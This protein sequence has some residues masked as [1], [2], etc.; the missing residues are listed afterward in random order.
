[1]KSSL[2]RR[3]LSSPTTSS[4]IA[5]VER[6]T[7][8][9]PLLIL[10]SGALRSRVFDG[11]H[12]FR[13]CASDHLS[14][15]SKLQTLFCCLRRHLR[16][17]GSITTAV[18]SV[19]Q[20]EEGRGAGPDPEDR[21]PLEMGVG[22]AYD[23]L[24]E[25]AALAVA[26]GGSPKIPCRAHPGRLVPAVGPLSSSTAEPE[27]M[28]VQERAKTV[29]AVT[30]RRASRFGGLLAQALRRRWSAPNRPARRRSRTP[31]IDL[32]RQRPARGSGDRRERLPRARLRHR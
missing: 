1:M 13:W 6:N 27:E 16:G 12:G 32:H 7:T 19:A 15:R 3:R 22:M 30:I 9:L 20:A 28:V 23:P 31:P 18:A 11:A 4:P 17:A 25:A 2:I 26:A 8:L 29:S 10:M 24:P 14:T 21:H 5:V